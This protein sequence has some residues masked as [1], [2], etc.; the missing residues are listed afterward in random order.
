MRSRRDPFR[1]GCA[2]AFGIKARTGLPAEDR[3][4]RLAG[5]APV[6]AHL[7]IAGNPNQSGTSALDGEAVTEAECGGVVAGDSAE[8]GKASAAG[9]ERLERLLQ[10]DAT[11]AA[12]RSK[13]S[14]PDQERR[15]AR[16]SVRAPACC[17][18]RTALPLPGLD[19]LLKAGV[20]EPAMMS[21]GDAAYALF[22]SVRYL[23]EERRHEER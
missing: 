3:R 1:P 4:R 2:T 13:T 11:P 8:V 19:P 17:R 16:P 15:S 23:Q 9:E 7:D 21:D 10:P 14:A 22:G 5:Q 12:R 6:P 20:I 18:R